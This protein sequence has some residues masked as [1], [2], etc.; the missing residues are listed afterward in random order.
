MLG[1]HYKTDNST[2]LDVPLT[3]MRF[4]GSRV[5][6]PP[7]RLLTKPGAVWGSVS[8]RIGSD[9]SKL[10][11]LAHDGEERFIVGLLV[12]L[13]ESLRVLPATLEWTGRA[14]RVLDSLPILV[15]RP[16]RG[17]G[18]RGSTTRLTRGLPA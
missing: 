8:T 13:E 5:Q 9:F 17:E 16:E 6:I 18:F 15:A 14:L 2:F 10:A 1:T 11:L 4:R 3:R 7:S 12:A